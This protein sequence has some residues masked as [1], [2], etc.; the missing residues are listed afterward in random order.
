MG[1]VRTS[2][3]QVVDVV[4]VVIVVALLLYLLLLHRCLGIGYGIGKNLLKL[5][6]SN[7]CCSGFCCCLRCC[8]FTYSDFLDVCEFD[9]VIVKTS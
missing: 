5:N 7:S 8:C 1:S 4:V 3:D 6:K 9:M 2:A